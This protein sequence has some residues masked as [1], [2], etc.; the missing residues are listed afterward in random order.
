MSKRV[1]GPGG[2][3]LPNLW[4]SLDDHKT[5]DNQEIPEKINTI[6]NIKQNS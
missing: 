5:P 1:L 2:R 3:T 4:L 6:R